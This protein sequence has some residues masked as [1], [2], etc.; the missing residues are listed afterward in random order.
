MIKEKS[1]NRISVLEQKRPT[2]T[3]NEGG[4]QITQE[5]EAM[6]EPW[7]EAI[8]LLEGKTLFYEDRP[9][10]GCFYVNDDPHRSIVIS[11]A[12]W[13]RILGAAL[14]STANEDYEALPEEDR[15]GDM[16]GM[17]DLI[18]KRVALKMIEQFKVY[19][20]TI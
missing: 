10:P 19:G 17:G 14:T 20:I 11:N 3:D 15:P 16:R 4:I 8:V 5:A 18:D 1:K 9:T 13:F 2:R 6:L 12:V 7:Q